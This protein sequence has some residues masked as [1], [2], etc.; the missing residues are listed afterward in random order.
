MQ[1][2]ELRTDIWYNDRSIELTFPDSWDVVVY[3]PNTPSALTDKDILRIINSPIE[4]PPLHILARG[5][6]TPCIVIDDLSRPTPIFRIMPFLLEEFSLAGIRSSDIRV[7]VATGTH[8]EQNGRALANKIGKEA[9]ESCRVIVHN[10]QKNTEFIGKTSFGTPVYVNKE[11]LRSDFLIGIGG[12]YPQHTTGFGGG[13]KLA[14][15]VLGRKSIMHLHYSHEGV[16]GTY[17]IENDFRKDVTEISRMIGLNTIYTLHVN[18]HLE[19]VNL[20]CGDHYMY[21]PQAAQFSKEKYSAHLPEDADVAI[22]N[23]Y[24]LDLSFTFMRKG[25]KP[26]DVA[27]KRATKVMIAS[28]YEGIGTHGLFQHM[29]PPGFIK[30]KILYRKISTMEPKVI[31]SKILK[32]LTLQ[33]RPKATA[34][35]MNYALPGNTDHLLVYRPHNDGVPIPQ[36]EGITVSS[37]WGE[38]LEEIKREQSS[39]KQIRVR[40]YPCA[41]LQCLDA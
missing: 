8:G 3:W 40:I 17:N 37:M 29:K 12:V 41:P 7:L 33:K 30:Y 27:P 21:Y 13:S 10:D 2:I 15:G 1:G 31:L 9:T 4:Q 19:T 25:Y 34:V 11:V 14:L 28:N 22:A 18:A 5:K 38:I 36:I 24:P 6:K 35:Q 26:L 20:M 32:R 39:D 23:A 16:G